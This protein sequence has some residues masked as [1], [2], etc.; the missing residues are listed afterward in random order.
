MAQRLSQ[1]CASSTLPAFNSRECQARLP[2]LSRFVGRP[3]FLCFGP[4]VSFW[5]DCGRDSG[6]EGR[7]GA[8]ICGRL[9][10]LI[11][12]GKANQ[13]SLLLGEA[14]GLRWEREREA[15]NVGA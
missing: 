9:C 7:E 4:S 3:V 2:A 12:T 13:F 8:A 1:A 5:P 11:L 10:K 14:Q 6:G 15:G